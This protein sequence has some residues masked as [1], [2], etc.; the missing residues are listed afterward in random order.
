M[1]AVEDDRILQQFAEVI[2]GFLLLRR[3]LGNVGQF[4]AGAGGQLVRAL[5]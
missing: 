4:H 1:T 3:F 2:V 5:P